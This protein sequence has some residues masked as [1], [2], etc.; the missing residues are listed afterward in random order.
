MSRRI[1]YAGS[2]HDDEEI[3]AVG[4]L[5]ADPLVVV[6]VAGTLAPL[7]VAE[8]VLV[9]TAPAVELVEIGGVEVL[10]VH[11]HVAA[12]VAVGRDHRVAVGDDTGTDGGHV[13]I[14]PD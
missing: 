6:P 2:V 5:L 12:R 11:L 7:E 8:R 13:T 1:E 4:L 14:P 9:A 3:D 10:P